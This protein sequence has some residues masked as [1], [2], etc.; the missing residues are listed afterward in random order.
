MLITL[1]NIRFFSTIN[2]TSTNCPNFSSNLDDAWVK[3]IKD[4]Q[5]ATPEV[6]PA[7]TAAKEAQIRL[8]GE[9]KVKTVP[10]V[11]AA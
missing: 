4:L 5:D 2:T 8:S 1:I 7:E 3:E 9:P 10:A 11:C 6:D